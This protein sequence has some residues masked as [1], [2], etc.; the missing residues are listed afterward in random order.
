MKA[1]ATASIPD[2]KG[3]G[4]GPRLTSALDAARA[5]AALYVLVYHVLLGLHLPLAIALPFRFGQEAVIAFFLL[6]GF[7]IFA[8]ERDRATMVGGYYLRRLRRIY[9]AVLLAMILPTVIAI[10]DHR[11]V[12]GF[13]WRD[14][15]GTLFAMQDIPS[16]KPAVIVTPYLDNDPLWSL[17][18]EVFFYVCFPLVLGCWKRAPTQTTN[19]IGAI[20]CGA[21]SVFVV[22]PNHWLLV[23]SYFLVWWAGAMAANSYLTKGRNILDMASAFFWLVALCAMAAVGIVVV[24]YSGIGLY[25]ALPLRHFAAAALMLVVLFGPFGRQLAELVLPFRS[26]AAFAASISYGLYVFHFPLLIQWHRARSPFGFLIALAILFALAYCADRVL[27][28]WLRRATLPS[29][30]AVSRS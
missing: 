23:A 10:D 5:A 28:D 2:G 25:P 6:S 29:I 4:L 13:S 9:P 7:V 17:S 19:V 22:A 8:N 11:F 12:T 14:L 21:Y 27:G 3:V 18:Y 20:C 24:G 26:A 16:L 30:R 1:S 15:F